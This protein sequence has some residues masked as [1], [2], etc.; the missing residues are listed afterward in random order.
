MVRAN[1]TPDRYLNFGLAS[2]CVEVQIRRQLRHNQDIEIQLTEKLGSNRVGVRRSSTFH[3]HNEIEIVLVEKGE[4]GHLMAGRLVW[5]HTG[6]LAVFWGA[7]PHTPLKVAPGTIFNWLT[8]PL[9]WVLEW[10]LPRA[11]TEALLSGETITEPDNR[12]GAVDLARFARWHGDLQDGSP[13]RKKIVLLECEARLRRLLLTASVSPGQRDQTGE[14]TR[15]VSTSVDRM[16]RFVASH[17][18]EPIRISD[19]AAEVGL[20]PNYAAL[21]FRK[22]CGISLSDYIKEHRFY[23]AQRLL[24]TTNEKILSIALSAGFG[25]ASRFYSS[26]NKAC[27]RTPRSYRRSMGRL[28]ETEIASE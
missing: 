13:E 5:I 11:F 6:R 1:S 9:T 25:S 12:E 19:I 28:F 14:A 23:H 7:V 10:H 22:T 8:I 2:M 26:F 4:I 27:S 16:T 24:A 20:H 15:L 17:Y 3:R 21:L 18:T